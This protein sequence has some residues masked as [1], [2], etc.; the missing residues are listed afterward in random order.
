MKE[1]ILSINLLRFFAAL[2]VLCVHKFGVF[3]EQGYLPQSLNFLTPF[4]QYGYLG[5]NLF[6]LISGFVIA[7]SSEGRTFG[8]FISARFIR[9]FPIFWVCVS[10]TTLIALFLEYNATISL[11]QYLANLTMQPRFYGNYDLIDGSYWTLEVELRFYCMIALILLLRPLINLSLRNVSLALTLP[12]FYYIFYYNPYSISLFGKIFDFVIYFFGSEYAQ[13]FIAGILFYEIY[14]H[15]KDIYSFIALTM[16]YIIAVLRALDEAYTSNDPIVIMLL[17]TF[18]FGLFLMI[19]LKKITN[20]SFLF[21]GEH[22]RALLI[23]LGAITYPLY[24]LH[25]RIIN[26]LLDSLAEKEIAPY[27]KS[28]LLFFI[29]SALIYLVNYLDTHIRFAWN[30]SSIIKGILERIHIPWIKKI[31]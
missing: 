7:L 6:F 29:F 19:S 10:I 2:A 18:F 16:C 3:I 9:L 26:A 24:L 21:L 8:Q 20:S 23:T 15:G 17:V 30:R 11:P 22:H 13:Y 25:S 28:F 14:K 31:L 1:E 12:M 27:I 5:V 4:T